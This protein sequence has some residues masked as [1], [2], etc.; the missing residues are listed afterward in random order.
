VVL[1][2]M[3]VICSGRVGVRGGSSTRSRRVRGMSVGVV[4][5]SVG[6]GQDERV[7]HVNGNAPGLF[8]GGGQHALERARR[9]G[10]A[11]VKREFESVGNE[12]R[13]LLG[14]HHAR[15]HLFNQPAAAGKG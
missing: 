15:Y 14:T 3:R 9:V 2:R 10:A 5:V 13:D 4:R 8:A 12:R 1:F 6:F 11:N 7:E